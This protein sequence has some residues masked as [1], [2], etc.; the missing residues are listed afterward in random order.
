MPTEKDPTLKTTMRSIG[1][2]SEGAAGLNSEDNT[3][4][5]PETEEEAP[6]SEAGE[7]DSDGEEGEREDGDDK[8]AK[9]ATGTHEIYLDG[10]EDEEAPPAEDKTAWYRMRK[11]K[12]EAEAKA[13]ALERRLQQTQAPSEDADPGKEP[14]QEEFLYD[15]EKYKEALFAWKERT[16]RFKQQ[17][18][19]KAEQAEAEARAARA[20]EQSYFSQK[21]ALAP[22]VQGYEEAERLVA[23]T[24]S[25]QHQDVLLAVVG[26]AAKVVYVLG[27][28]PEKLAELA[29]ETNRDKFVAGLVRLEMSMKERKRGTPPPP[30]EVPRGGGSPSKSG[31]AELEAAEKRAEK[32]RDRS[33]VRAILRRRKA[34]AEARR[35]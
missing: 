30:E 23:T 33:E 11:A 15:N 26:N 17:Q 7:L 4:V 1:E 9:P 28:R 19:R 24:L 14:T 10:E 18:A 27:R 22:K 3:T 16:E 12:Q 34:E 21:S 25:P 5:A 8:G 13:E 35:R 20:R 32:S 6:E 31:D 2:K 29:K